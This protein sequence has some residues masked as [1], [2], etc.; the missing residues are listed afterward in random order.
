MKENEIQVYKNLGTIQMVM[1]EGKRW[2]ISTHRFFNE[3]D[4]AQT[5]KEARENLE[6]QE[7][8]AKEIQ[9][10]ILL[11]KRHKYRVFKEIA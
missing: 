10:A 5:L 3:Q 6:Y 11:L 1:D 7:A 8:R 2:Y 9:A 4:E